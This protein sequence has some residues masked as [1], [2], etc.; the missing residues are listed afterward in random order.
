MI[1]LA[2]FVF[3]VQAIADGDEDRA[4]HHAYRN[5]RD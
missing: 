3:K 4:M 5:A 1:S 2:I